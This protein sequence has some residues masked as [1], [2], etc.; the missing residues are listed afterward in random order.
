MLASE[1]FTI[2][3]TSLRAAVIAAVLAVLPCAALAGGTSPIL[4]LT[5]A[6]AARAASGAETVAVHGSFNFGDLIEG[7]FPAGLVVWSGTHFVRFDQAGQALGG[8]A[9][10]LADGLVA[11][12]VP[13]LLALGTPA[14][15]PAAL[16]QL[17]ADRIAVVLPAGFPSGPA[18]VALVAVHEG[19]SFASNTVAVTLP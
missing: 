1:P 19:E 4:T 11:T 17:R 12:E 14:A 10:F 7:I 13:S 16:A 18:S 6:D 15:A 5:G 8:D 3:R 2:M 9:P